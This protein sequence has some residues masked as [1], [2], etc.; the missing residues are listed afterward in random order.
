MFALPWEIFEESVNHENGFIC[1]R[2]ADD[3]DAAIPDYYSQNL[4]QLNSQLY[5]LLLSKDV[6]PE[7]QVKDIFDSNYGDAYRLIC[8]TMHLVHPNF[9]TV[10]SAPC[11]GAPAREEN[12]TFEQHIQKYAYF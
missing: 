3:V 8:R 5:T 12:E 7:A 11:T 4:S 6:L 10:S 9:L 2:T 1:A